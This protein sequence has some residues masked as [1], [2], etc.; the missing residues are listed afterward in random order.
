MGVELAR[1]RLP[2]TLLLDVGANVTL[3]LPLCPAGR[4]SGRPLRLNPDPVIAAWETVRSDPP[5]LP[6][7]SDC[8]AL[9]PT[10]TL[11]KLMLDGLTVSWAVA[12]SEYRRMFS[13]TSPHPITLH[14]KPRCLTAWPF[15]RRA[16][17]A[18]AGGYG[19]TAPSIPAEHERLSRLRVMKGAASAVFPEDQAIERSQKGM[20]KG[21]SVS[22][23]RVHSTTFWVITPLMGNPGAVGLVR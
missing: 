15:L 7:T 4:V 1:D 5:E 16:N 17:A 13:R 3:K 22:T 20:L 14:G 12:T 2:L 23:W 10:G 6:R 18:R 21:F 19:A 9:L 11:P 8:V